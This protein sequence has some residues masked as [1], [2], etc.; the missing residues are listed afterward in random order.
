MKILIRTMTAAGIALMAS[1][2][3]VEAQ[4][5]G[6]APTQPGQ[7]QQQAGQNRGGQNQGGQN[8]V[9]GDGNLPG[10]IDSLSDAQD[11]GRML[12]AMADT[13]H[14]GQISSK[15]ATDAAN[16]I[17]GG[18][19][20]RADQNG[21]GALSQEEAKSAREALFAQQPMLRYVVQTGQFQAKQAGNNAAANPV[22]S[23]G[24]LLDSNNDKQLQATEVRGAVETAIQG[25]FAA[26]DTNRD[27]QMTPTEIN[28]AI[29]GAV[30]TASQ[31]AFQQADADNNG[32]LS[33]DEFTKAITQPA[34]FVFSVLDGNND[35]QITQQEAQQAQRIIG[36]QIQGLMVP[37]PANSA[38]NLIQTGTPPGQI[39]P[40]PNLPVP[41]TGAGGAAAPGA[42][43]AP[44]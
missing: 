41:N 12:F 42:A 13:N 33:S 37:E 16:L 24:N 20:F 29:I 22:A 10:P 4:A 6:Q 35:G 11:T 43:P 28:A 2:A 17:V 44:R 14:D 25:L 27:G 21:D 19:F 9:V 5:P 39:A 7:N 18:F 15:E 1:A 30:R 8:R 23:I 32:S 36:R 38:R 34:S 31:A 40:V 26:A 3:S